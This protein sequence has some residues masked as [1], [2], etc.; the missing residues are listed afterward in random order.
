[1]IIVDALDF[2]Q[3]EKTLTKAFRT[4]LTWISFNL[5]VLLIVFSIFSNDKNN[6]DPLDGRSGLTVYTDNLT[7]CQYLGRTYGSLVPRMN[8][9]GEQVCE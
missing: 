2:E 3:L 6:S 4:N 7:G 9:N 8:E 1:M 5:L